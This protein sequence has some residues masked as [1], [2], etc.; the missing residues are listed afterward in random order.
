MEIQVRCIIPMISMMLLT[1]TL[2]TLNEERLKQGQ[3]GEA[4]IPIL[5]ELDLTDHRI[6]EPL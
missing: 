3:A 4:D 6:G 5:S 1:K 2:A